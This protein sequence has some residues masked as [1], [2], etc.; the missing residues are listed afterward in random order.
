MKRPNSATQNLRKLYMNY[1]QKNFIPPSCLPN[2]E[3]MYETH[4]YIKEEALEEELSLLQISWDELGITP[5][6]RSVF[7]NII[8]QANEA[9]KINIF[10]QEKN[11]IKKLRESLLGLKKEIENRE[12]N[13]TQLKSFNA[14]VQNIINSGDDVNSINQ[15][16][17]NVINLINL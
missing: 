3:N 16:L 2:L 4:N 6:Y 15:I 17:Q 13:L 11:N 10:S 9:E 1:Q 8:S 14:L 12:N 7:L 5:Q